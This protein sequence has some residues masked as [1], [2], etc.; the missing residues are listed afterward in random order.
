MAGFLNTAQGSDVRMTVQCS[1]GPQS[2]RTAGTKVEVWSWKRIW[3]GVQEEILQ[4]LATPAPLLFAQKKNLDV[5][6]SSPS[7]PKQ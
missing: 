5:L 6:G 2:S 4:D 7:W 1:D 3:E